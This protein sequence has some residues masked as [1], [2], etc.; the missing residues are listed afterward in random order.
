[1]A[2]FEDG[3]VC[4][5]VPKNN[6]PWIINFK[7]HINKPVIRIN[8]SSVNV[9]EK[10][11]KSLLWIS[12][13][14]Q[15]LRICIISILNILFRGMSGPTFKASE[16]MDKVCILKGI[17]HYLC[18]FY[19]HTHMYKV[20]L[21]RIDVPTCLGWPCAYPHIHVCMKSYVCQFIFSWILDG[22]MH[23]RTICMKSYLCEFYIPTHLGRL[24]AYLDTDVYTIRYV[25][26]YIFMGLGQLCGCPDI[27]V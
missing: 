9:V 17:D 5:F 27:Y 3:R 2:R 20:I 23:T 7:A 6:H 19:I 14:V 22:C 12:R 1:M 18:E 21:V 4:Q 25:L 8:V 10:D 24:C 13:M 16:F 15:I 11:I 26:I